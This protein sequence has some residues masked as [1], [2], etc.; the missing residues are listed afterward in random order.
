MRLEYL[1]D[2][3]DKIQQDPELKSSEKL[4]I[5]L[6][7]I[8]DSML[9]DAYLLTA[10]GEIRDAFWETSSDG[11]QEDEAAV[12]LVE[13]GPDIAAFHESQPSS[14]D[15]RPNGICTGDLYF[16]C[17]VFYNSGDERLTVDGDW[18]EP[19]EYRLSR[20]WTPIAWRF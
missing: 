3:I 1:R 17:V 12:Q 16:P 10:G 4:I 5:C 6:N 15:G 19:G 2:M 18:V 8:Y 14:R 13:G 9:E 20:S 7:R 11:L